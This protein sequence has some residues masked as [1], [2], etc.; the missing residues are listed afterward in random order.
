MVLLSSP[1]DSEYNMWPARLILYGA[2]LA[3]GAAAFAAG[4]KLEQPV[5]MIFSS[6]G[7]VFIDAHETETLRT[8]SP[9]MMLFAGYT[10]RNGGGTVRFSFCPEKAASGLAPGHEAPLLATC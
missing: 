6:T 4:P 10:I 1:G 8:A 5:G 7:A 9:G 2:F 3:A